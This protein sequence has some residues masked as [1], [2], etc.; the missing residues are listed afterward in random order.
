M[1]KQRMLYLA[2][3][4]A[5]AAVFVTQLQRGA[6]NGGS[7]FKRDAD[8]EG[9]VQLDPQGGSNMVREEPPLRIKAERHDTRL[10]IEVASRVALSQVSVV[11]QR[12][13]TA[14]AA[15]AA[16][17]D[18]AWSGAMDA[19]GDRRVQFTLPPGTPVEARFV[20]SARGSDAAGGRIA[21]TTV[22]QADAPAK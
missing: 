12:F 7:L 17:A 20:I 6:K 18:T 5:V 16:A 11:V 10:E 14:T 3:A 22:V 2:L 9:R 13:E 15:E 8:A 19:G 1:A 21:A 4:V